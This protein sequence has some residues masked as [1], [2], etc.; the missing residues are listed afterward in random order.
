MEEKE[1]PDTVSFCPKIAPHKIKA[2]R[3]FTHTD[4]TLMATSNRHA[5]CDL[6]LILAISKYLR[7]GI[8]LSIAINAF[9]YTA[10]VVFFECNIA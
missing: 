8:I 7:M 2:N 6:K 9:H 4:S 5:N 10:Y 3:I 1:N